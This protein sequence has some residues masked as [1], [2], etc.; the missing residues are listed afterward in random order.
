MNTVSVQLKSGGH[1]TGSDFSGKCTNSKS[2]CQFEKLTKSSLLS[3]QCWP[4]VKLFWLLTDRWISLE[5]R[6]WP[7]SCHMS[8]SLET[9]NDNLAMRLRIV[10]LTSCSVTFASNSVFYSRCL[11]GFESKKSLRVLFSVHPEILAS[12]LCEVLN[13]N[14]WPVK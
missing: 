10:R 12:H 1:L 3:Q 13:H 2:L 8:Q 11:C 4:A 7:D 6:F 9:L 5:N 14:L